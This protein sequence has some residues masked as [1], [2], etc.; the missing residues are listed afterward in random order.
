MMPPL[1]GI[2]ARS[3]VA[4]VLS[5]FVCG[6]LVTNLELLVFCLAVMNA[7][8]HETN[9]W[10]TPFP[11]QNQVS[12]VS[13]FVSGGGWEGGKIF[14][15]LLWGIGPPYKTNSSWQ[16]GRH[17]LEQCVLCAEC[18]LWGGAG[19]L[20]FGL[21]FLVLVFNL[22]TASA[23][24]NNCHILQVLDYLYL[25]AEEDATNL[26]KLKD[27]GV[28][29]VLNCAGGYINTGTDFYGAE[30]E[31]LEFEAED[32]DSY[33]MMQ[34]F[35]TAYQFIEGARKAGGKVMLHCIM[36]INRSGLLT[37]AYCMVN[38]N[39]GPISAARLVKKVRPMLLTN[40][41]FQRQLVTFARE[42]GLLHLDQ[43]E[44]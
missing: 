7:S 42:K 38:K 2:S 8:L 26:T 31:Y 25:G 43:D 44:L 13:G 20:F 17:S 18:L 12:F 4:M 39:T 10:F 19:W 34:H 16:E 14:V 33:D 36:G 37:V 27:L 22:P 41:G 29:H 6:P 1:P 21:L 35:D 24:I 32:D 5:V 30:V 15:S 23:K 9:T 11:L 3:A 28:T 40:R